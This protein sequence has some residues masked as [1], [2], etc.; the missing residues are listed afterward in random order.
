MDTRRQR[1][2]VRIASVLVLALA[3][4]PNA[5]FVGHWPFLPG[6]ERADSAAAEHGHAGHCHLG[7]S[8]CADGPSSGSTLPALVDGSSI[9]LLA[10]GLL[11]L[12][13]AP[14]SRPLAGVAFRFE[15]PPRE[16]LASVTA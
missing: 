5:L 16:T 7:P 10:G 3:V 15:R 13:D 4:L 14:V 6:F 9:V 2:F 1:R 11:M 8:R 12:L